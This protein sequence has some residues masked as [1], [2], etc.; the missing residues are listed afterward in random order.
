MENSKECL[1]DSE[2]KLFKKNGYAIILDRDFG[3]PIEKFNER[4]N[5]VVSQKPKTEEEYEQVVKMSRIFRNV[6]WDH[7]EYNPKLMK[8]LED[9]M[10]N[11]YEE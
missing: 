6:K 8:I 2:K 9:M 10:K 11:T 5:F 4:G 1:F 3:E 7:V